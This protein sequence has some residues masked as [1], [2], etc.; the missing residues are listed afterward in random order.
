MTSDEA[1]NLVARNTSIR[2]SDWCD[3]LDVMFVLIAQTKAVPAKI[4]PLLKLSYCEVVRGPNPPA[5]ILSHTSKEAIYVQFG[6][7][8]VTYSSKETYRHSRLGS[9]H[10]PTFVSP[11][12]KVTP[13]GYVTAG[14]ISVHLENTLDFE[15]EFMAIPPNFSFEEDLILD[16][17]FVRMERKSVLPSKDFV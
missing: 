6:T 10:L 3:A 15:R 2:P 8:T 12:F 13:E 5:F 1:I 17:Q 4:N 9:I 14:W 7:D 11:A 16:K